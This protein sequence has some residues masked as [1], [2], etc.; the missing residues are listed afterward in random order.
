[1]SGLAKTL[2]GDAA[3]VNKVATALRDRG[4]RQGTYD[5]PEL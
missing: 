5:S 4:Q 1:M 3:T 2:F